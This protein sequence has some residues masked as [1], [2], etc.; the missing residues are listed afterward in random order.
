MEDTAATHGWETGGHRRETAY[1]FNLFI[2]GE[3]AVYSFAKDHMDLEKGLQGLG[4]LIEGPC[5]RL[6]EWSTKGASFLRP[7]HMVKSVSKTQHM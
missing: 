6:Q 3:S 2:Q 1:Q 4:R 7:E 5:G